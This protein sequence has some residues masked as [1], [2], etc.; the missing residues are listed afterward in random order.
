MGRGLDFSTPPAYI[1][2]STTELAAVGEFGSLEGSENRT[3]LEAVSRGEADGGRSRERKENKTEADGGRS[4]ERKETELEARR[5][6][7]R[8]AEWSRD[9]EE[10]SGA[11]QRAEW[12][13]PPERRRCG[14]HS[15]EEFCR[16]QCGPECPLAEGSGSNSPLPYRALR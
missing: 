3:E 6:K 14:G 8:V 11:S 12:G 10:G 1:R 13:P 15:Q 5:R 7:G 9:A 16:S 4:T 2:A